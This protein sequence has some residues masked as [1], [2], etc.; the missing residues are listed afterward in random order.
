MASG[1]V[2]GRSAASPRAD[3][4]PPASRTVDAAV[5]HRPCATATLVLLVLLAA[6]PATGA[7][8]ADA[9]EEAAPDLEL[10]MYLGLWDE[11]DAGWLELMHELEPPGSGDDDEQE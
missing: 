3:A 7:A 6:A 4:P 1:P 5:P 9:D 8:A 11:E 2:H 10:L